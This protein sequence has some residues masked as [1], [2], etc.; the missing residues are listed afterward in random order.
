[1]LLGTRRHCYV[2][3]ACWGTR[4]WHLVWQTLKLREPSSDP[5]AEPRGVAGQQAQVSVRGQRAGMCHEPHHTL[6]PGTEKPAPHVPFQVQTVVIPVPL[7]LSMNKQM[8]K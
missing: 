5:Q 3:G 4:S 6:D 2:Q 8:N 1:M 7:K